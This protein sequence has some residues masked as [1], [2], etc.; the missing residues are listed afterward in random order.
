MIDNQEKRKKTNGK[1]HSGILL[2][3]LLDN[4]NNKRIVKD[5]D[6]HFLHIE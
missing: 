2:L 6:I 1:Y 4:Y 5:I 3:Y